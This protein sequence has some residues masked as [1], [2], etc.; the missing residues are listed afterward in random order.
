MFYS[1]ATSGEPA[2]E[3]NYFLSPLFLFF[4]PF[5]PRLK[6]VIAFLTA[7]ELFFGGGGVVIE[8]CGDTWCP[9]GRLRSSVNSYKKE[10]HECAAVVLISV[11]V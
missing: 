10:S 11:L 2:V 8:R 4:F 6:N 3:E 1:R 5:S 7:E 9:E